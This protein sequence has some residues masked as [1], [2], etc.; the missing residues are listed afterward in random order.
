MENQKR[1]LANK[2]KQKKR[3]MITL[4]VKVKH[5]WIIEEIADC[6]N[7]DTATA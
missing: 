5:K 4:K 7:V 1:E 2:V 6:G 3:I